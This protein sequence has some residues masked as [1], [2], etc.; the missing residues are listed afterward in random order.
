MTL[1]IIGSVPGTYFRLSIDVDCQQLLTPD[2]YP[3]VRYVPTS[4]RQPHT[5]HRRQVLVAFCS[6]SV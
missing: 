2:R 1:A 4:I 5:E 6:L 3:Y